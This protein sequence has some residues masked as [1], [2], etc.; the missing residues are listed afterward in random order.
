[1]TTNESDFLHY[2]K[3]GGME[4]VGKYDIPKVK[5][6]KL[7]HL[8][9]ADVLGFN[10]CTNK[11]NLT[12]NSKKWVHFFLPDAYIE[13]VWDNP[14]YYGPVFNQYSGI[15][16]PDFSQYVG[17]PRAMLIW[18]HYRRMWLAQY[19]QNQGVP[20]IAAPCWSDEESFDYCFEG[21]P[22]NSCLCISSVGCVQNPYVR[23]RFNIGLQETLDRL[24]PKQV[25]LY[26][27][28]DDDLRARLNKAGCDYI[29]IDSE[30]KQRIEK[31]K[32]S[33]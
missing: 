14:E 4:L 18:Q 27:C 9:K 24:T 7:K 26:G 31:Y 2:L 33:L 11:E 6:I 12:S 17:M 30:M 8:N 29:H 15:I 3:T 22:H 10:Y 23:E 28:I 16:Q 21:M 20:V 1:M 19:Y 32:N 13:R 5:G 25:I